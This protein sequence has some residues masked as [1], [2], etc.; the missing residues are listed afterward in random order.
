[1]RN[2]GSK[3]LSK[4][5][6]AVV[7]GALAAV[8]GVGGALAFLTD[9][10]QVTNQFS[11]AAFSVEV[12]EPKWDAL[13]DENSNDIPDDAENVTPGREITKDPL[14]KND[15][16]VPAY[17]FI[18]VD[19]PYA[20]V[21]TY[22]EEGGVNAAADTELF[23][24]TK[25]SEKWVAL[26]DLVDDTEND[27]MSYWYYYTDVVDPGASTDALFESVTFANL[28][29]DQLVD[30]ALNQ[31][32][33]VTGFGIQSEGFDS[34]TDAWTAYTSQNDG[35]DMFDGVTLPTIS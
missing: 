33:V 10:D 13:P 6:L 25:S 16:T 2:F 5:K 23:S 26:G 28:I 19:V 29:E 32:I 24:F 9:W 7:G 11:V 27:V 34:A 15:S 12:Q 14:V 20:N 8:V 18:K 17:L 3:G 1:M 4:A 35:G 30:D 21:K 22:N 31:Q